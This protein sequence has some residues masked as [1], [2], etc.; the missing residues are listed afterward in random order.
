MGKGSR[1]P[2][3]DSAERTPR[4]GG[5]EGRIGGGREWLGMGAG[6]RSTK[7]CQRDPQKREEQSQEKRMPRS[8]Q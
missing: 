3:L 6:L 4:T 1:I 2:V 7:E 5:T 8:T